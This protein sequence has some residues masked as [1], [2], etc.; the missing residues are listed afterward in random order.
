MMEGMYGVLPL[1]CNLL[2]SYLRLF[3]VVTLHFTMIFQIANLN[4]QDDRMIQEKF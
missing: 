3:S 4:A 1:S 2:G